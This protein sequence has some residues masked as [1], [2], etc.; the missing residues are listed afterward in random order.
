MIKGGPHADGGRLG[1]LDEVDLQVYLASICD[2]VPKS[3]I[4]VSDKLELFEELTLKIAL[5][6]KTKVNLLI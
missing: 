1:H 3:Q 2:F 5:S 4:H 6:C